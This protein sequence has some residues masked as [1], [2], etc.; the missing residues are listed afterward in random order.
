MRSTSFM[1][2]L[3]HGSLALRRVAVMAVR[4]AREAASAALLW[5]VPE[6]RD[7]HD[8]AAAVALEERMTDTF[9]ECFTREQRRSTRRCGALQ[10][11]RKRRRP[12]RALG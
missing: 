1:P 2:T 11:C 5:R 6:A 9:G 8:E 12:P 7:R 4:Q 10:R 3:R